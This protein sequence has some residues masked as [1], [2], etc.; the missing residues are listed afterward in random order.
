M[1]TVESVIIDPLK[2]KMEKEKAI[3]NLHPT[4]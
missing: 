1:K 2:E 3:Q 4:M